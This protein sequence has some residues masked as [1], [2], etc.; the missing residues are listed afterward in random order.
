MGR[1]TIKKFLI[2]LSEPLSTDTWCMLMNL[3]MWRI[4][5]RIND[6]SYLYV[7]SILYGSPLILFVTDFLHYRH[8]VTIYSVIIIYC[9]IILTSIL[10]LLYM[11]VTMFNQTE[12]TKIT[13]LNIKKLC[14][15]IGLQA[16]LKYMF[17][18]IFTQLFTY[19]CSDDQLY[20]NFV[21]NYVYHDQLKECV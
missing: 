10:F 19:Q 8:K 7:I 11:Y 12:I 16:G 18:S 9:T 4:L 17:A 5:L 15:R 1:N 14:S 3:V 21:F 13:N 20:P 2:P 6:G